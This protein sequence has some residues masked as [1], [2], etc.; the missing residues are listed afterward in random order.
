MDASGTN[1]S[2]E[3]KEKFVW[4]HSPSMYARYDTSRVVERGKFVGAEKQIQ[5]KEGDK[6]IIKA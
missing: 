2:G 4:F 1:I 5:D 6:W 3:V